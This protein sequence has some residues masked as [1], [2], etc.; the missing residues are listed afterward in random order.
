VKH[1]LT[2]DQIA[3]IR[4]LSRNS[5][6]SVNSNAVNK[7]DLLLRQSTTTLNTQ[8]TASVYDLRKDLSKNTTNSVNSN[9]VVQ[10]DSIAAFVST[11]ALV[12]QDAVS[13]SGETPEGGNFD[14]A[15]FAASYRSGGTAIASKGFGSDVLA[16]RGIGG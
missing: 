13:S 7:S 6:N 16:A 15:S 8:K 3:G 2:A 4:S 11:A 10:A 14:V 9:A 1:S 12:P 5:V